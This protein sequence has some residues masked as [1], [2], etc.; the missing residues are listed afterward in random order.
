MAWSRA[1][2]DS[3]RMIFALAYWANEAWIY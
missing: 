3:W 1:S 2:Y